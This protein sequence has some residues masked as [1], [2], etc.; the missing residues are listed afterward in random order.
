MRDEH[1][2][3]DFSVDLSS[4]IGSYSTLLLCSRK[5]QLDIC[6]ELWRIV[7]TFYIVE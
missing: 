3:L 1:G 5:G 2:N 4:E 7:K 6:V